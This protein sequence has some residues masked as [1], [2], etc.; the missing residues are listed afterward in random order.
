MAKLELGGRMRSYIV[1]AALV[2]GLA[3]G[4]GGAAT[5]SLMRPAAPKSAIEAD[6]G[7]QILKEA[8]EISRMEDEYIQLNDKCR[9]GPGDSDF[10]L[11]ACD[12]REAVGDKLKAHGQCYEG[13]PMAAQ[14]GWIRCPG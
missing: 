11:R 4:V 10:T 13:S 2:G 6:P 1:V 9:G 12:A 5:F 3:A 7:Y 14:Q 8:S